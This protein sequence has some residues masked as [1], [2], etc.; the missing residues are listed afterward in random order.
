MYIWT[1]EIFQKISWTKKC[2]IKYFWR[3][4][5]K[6]FSILCNFSQPLHEISSKINHDDELN[7]VYL[8][9]VEKRNCNLS[10]VFITEKYGSWC[11][12]KVALIR[13]SSDLRGRIKRIKKI[14]INWY[15]VMS[16]KSWDLWHES[17]LKKVR[18]LDFH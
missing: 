4:V 10:H 3:K 11:V 5:P 18:P 8:I 6:L 15:F 13:I 16:L 12:R 2:Y 9:L 1:F 7:F 14:S 17:Q